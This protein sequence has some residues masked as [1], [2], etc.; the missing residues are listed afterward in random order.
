MTKGKKR[1]G[2]RQKCSQ[3]KEP[4]PPGELQAPQ[5]GESGEG[6]GGALGC[7]A[8]EFGLYSKGGARSLEGGKQE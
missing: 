3:Q 2:R 7:L 4:E 1:W 5:P 6:G 8:V